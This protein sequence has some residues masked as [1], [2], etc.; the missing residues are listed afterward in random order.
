MIS[1]SLLLLVTAQAPTVVPPAPTP[2]GVGTLPPPVAVP[3]APIP[4]QV[5][6]P[7]PPPPPVV[8]AYVP[9]VPVLTFA[10]ACSTFKTFGPGMHD[11][12]VCHPCTGQPVRVCLKLPCKC[13]K[14]L[15]DSCSCGGKKITFKVKGLFNDVVVM[16]NKDGTVS[17]KS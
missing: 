4:G 11:V 16:F 3:V 6:V 7:V 8:S 17:V 13:F 10:D 5:L 15:C 12:M 9:A 14:V 1:L 2:P